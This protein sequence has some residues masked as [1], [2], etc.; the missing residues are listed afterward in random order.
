[1]Y[2]NKILCISRVMH[3]YIE[4]GMGKLFRKSG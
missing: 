4:N 2:K 1:M 3:V